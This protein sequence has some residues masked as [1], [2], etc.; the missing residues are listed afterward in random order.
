[1]SK[2]NKCIN[3]AF[4]CVKRCYESGGGI[5]GH[6]HSNTYTNTL[7]S[8]ERNSLIN[9]DSFYYLRNNEKPQEKYEEKIKEEIKRIKEEERINEAKARK[10]DSILGNNV[11][12]SVLNFSKLGNNLQIPALGSVNP[13]RKKAMENL[14][15]Q[16]ISDPEIDVA[17]TVGISCHYGKFHKAGSVDYLNNNKCDDFY[18][19]KKEFE[20]MPIKEIDKKRLRDLE[21]DNQKSTEY[22]L[23]LSK[24][25]F[26]IS[27]GVAIISVISIGISIYSMNSTIY[28]SKKS[29]EYSK[30][31]DEFDK[32]WKISQEKQNKEIIR[33]NGLSNNLLTIINTESKS[34]NLKLEK[35]LNLVVDNL[36]NINTGFI[37]LKH[38]NKDNK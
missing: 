29:L 4:C 3:C 20:S 18:K 32:E 27:I 23:K 9:D 11:M 16:G 36:E 10:M 31:D 6:F 7:S 21:Y 13:Y 35:Q 17:N 14:E 25:A 5:I 2:D 26:W 37:K 15:R 19:F 8:I 33:L 30:K 28:Y 34:D 22:N 1:M 24:R 12:S 38:N